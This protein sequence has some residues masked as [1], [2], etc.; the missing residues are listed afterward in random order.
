MNAYVMND[1]FAVEKAVIAHDEAI[2]NIQE[3][4]MP[5]TMYDESGRLIDNEDLVDKDKLKND[6]AKYAASF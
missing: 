2:N 3:S 4:L 1:E 5:Q 6:A